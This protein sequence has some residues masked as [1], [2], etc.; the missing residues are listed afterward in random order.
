[1]AEVQRLQT[2]L[3]GIEGNKAYA[4]QWPRLKIIRRQLDDACRTRFDRGVR[5]SLVAPLADLTVPVD[6]QAQTALESAARDLRKLQT[7]AR[8][9]GDPAGYDALL[10]TASD[11]VLTAADTGALT[12]MRKYRL[13]EILAGSDAAEA[14]Y[15]RA[16]R[17]G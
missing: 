4:D 9:G 8:K 14:L 7:T 17:G 11:A 6:G 13:I 16:A 3:G 1:V 12:P 2:L 5:E 15:A 10:R